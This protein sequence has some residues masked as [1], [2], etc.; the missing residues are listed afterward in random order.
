MKTVLE[1]EGERL[2]LK[3]ILS[4]LELRLFT[5]LKN[6]TEFMRYGMDKPAGTTPN[7]ADIKRVEA[8]AVEAAD[9]LHAADPDYLLHR[10]NN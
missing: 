9:A 5:A 3:P 7:R 4:P 2:E 1:F 10:P 6:F 8:L